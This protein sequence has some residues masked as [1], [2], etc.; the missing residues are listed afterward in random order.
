MASLAPALSHALAAEPGGARIPVEIC[1]SD[2]PRQIMQI[3]M[4]PDSTDTLDHAFHLE[5]CPFCR[6][7]GDA[8]GGRAAE[9]P[10]LPLQFSLASRP[11]LFYH[12]LN[13]LFAWTTPQSR[14]PPFFS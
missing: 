5:D 12:S 6:I 9:W 13:P 1:T 8:P 10:G 4:M 2:G 3:V 14:A 11:W 7:S